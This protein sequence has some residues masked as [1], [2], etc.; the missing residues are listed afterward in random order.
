MRRIASRVA[1]GA[2]VLIVSLAL[3]AAPTS[4]HQRDVKVPT[5]TG[6]ASLPALTFVPGSEP[7]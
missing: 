3:L 5:L 4:A 7:S 6:F 1:G 2:G